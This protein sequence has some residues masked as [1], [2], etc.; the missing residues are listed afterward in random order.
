MTSQSFVFYALLL[1]FCYVQTQLI[2]LLLF[3]YF[4]FYRMTLLVNMILPN[5]LPTGYAL[6]GFFAPQ[7][8]ALLIV[9]S[10]IKRS[11]DLAL[12]IYA[13]CR[14]CDPRFCVCRCKILVGQVILR[15]QIDIS[16]AMQA[17]NQFT[18]TQ[19]LICFITND[20][21]YTCTLGH[22]CE[23]MILIANHT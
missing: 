11:A 19:R 7:F 10:P 5:Y 13:P 3:V 1:S 21:R 20:L 22:A 14:S 18:V 6:Y 16:V 12:T 4:V 15:K 8:C 23:S 9:C 2:I 17:V